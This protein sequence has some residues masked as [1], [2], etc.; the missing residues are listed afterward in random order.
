MTEIQDT[1]VKIFITIALSFMK[2]I[3][4]LHTARY[5]AGHL[6]LAH[7]EAAH[8][9]LEAALA[10]T[11]QSQGQLAVT[12]RKVTKDQIRA[13]DYVRH[14]SELVYAT[15]LFDTFLTDATRFLFLLQPKSVGK[16]SAVSLEILLSSNSKSEA[17][18]DAVNRK[19]R[20]LGHASFA[21]RIDTLRQTFGLKIQSSPNVL[22][23]FNHYTTIRNVV[24]HDQAFYDISLTD[25]GLIAVERNSDVTPVEHDDVRSAISAYT[26]VAHSIAEAVFMDVLHG[27]RDKE[28]H[29]RMDSF[30]KYASKQEA[31]ILKPH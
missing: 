18:T 22:N 19:V 26:V 2:G 11:P 16:N 29:R 24:I 8:A 15:T 14:I 1:N 3:V 20:E 12:L 5:A 4:R 25:A 6:S 23:I 28:A 10:E 13:L 9:D 27:E 21:A 30:R 7:Y 31:E 17:I